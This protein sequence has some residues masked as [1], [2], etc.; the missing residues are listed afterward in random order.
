MIASSLLALVVIATP[1]IPIADG[2]PSLDITSICKATMSDSAA[3]TQACIDD[4]EK[5]RQTLK[6]QWGQFTAGDH[7]TC[8]RTAGMAG[9]PSYVEILTCL[10]MAKDARELPAD[11]TG[12]GNR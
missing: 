12:R 1:V 2:V 6:E 8:A 3:S 7:A 9:M 10:E 4:E 11:I 5:A